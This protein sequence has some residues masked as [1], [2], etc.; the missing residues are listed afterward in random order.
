MSFSSHGRYSINAINNVI[1]V[2]GHGPYNEELLTAYN[3]DI[4]RA[5][6]QVK[7]NYDHWGQIVY[8]HDNALLSPE[9][10]IQLEMESKWLHLNKGFTHCAFILVDMEASSLVQK[11]YAGLLSASGIKSIFCETLEEAKAWLSKEIKL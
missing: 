5:I 10:E 6:E 2:D 1:I 11:Q 8:L 4:T 7:K 9:A 3:L